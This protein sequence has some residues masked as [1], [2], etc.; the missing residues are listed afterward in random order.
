MNHYS[1]GYEVA[2][3]HEQLQRSGMRNRS[4]SSTRGQRRWWFSRRRT[5]TPRTSERPAPLT[6][7]VPAVATAGFHDWATEVGH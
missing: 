4:K 7:V 1:A 2:Y 6:P 5:T 3:R